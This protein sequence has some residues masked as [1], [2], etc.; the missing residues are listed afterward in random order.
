MGSVLLMSGLLVVAWGLGVTS[1]APPPGNPGNPFQA[2]L[3]K[4]DQILAVVT[5]LGGT[6][7]GNHTLRWDTSNPSASRFATAFDGAVLD[8]NTG[9][10]WEQA[11]DAT[12]HPW[13]GATVS[14]VGRNVGNTSGW[15]LP[16]VVELKSVQDPSLPAPFVPAT[17]FTGVQST[18]Y[19]SASRLAGTPAFGWV[20]S[21]GNDIVAGD[22]VATLHHVWCVRGPM[23]EAEY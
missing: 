11:L 20:V 21:F 19:W 23:Q 4:L 12:Q 3:A 2:I 10:V 14:C 9:L 16:S 17:V 7:N 1:A 22:T 13:A 6:S 5:G 8:K 15:R 18:L